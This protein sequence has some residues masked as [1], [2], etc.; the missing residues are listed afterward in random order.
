[1]QTFQRIAK[2]FLILFLALTLSIWL[3]SSPIIK[4]FLKAPLA[5]QGLSLSGQS[6]IRFNPFLTRV[7]IN[8]LVLTK[9]QTQT[10]VLEIGELTLQLALHQLLFDNIKVQT[11]KIDNLYLQVKQLPEKLE[12]AGFV[13][14]EQGAPAT[15]PSTKKV[16]EQTPTEFAYTVIMPALELSK[17][18]I[19][20]FAD[21]QAHNIH[22]DKF[23]VTDVTASITK[24][25]SQLSLTA[26]V[27]NAKT[28]FDA[29]VLYQNDATKI[30]S[31]FSLAQYPLAKLQGHLAGRVAQ[32]SQLEGKLS[33]ITEQKITLTGK[34]LEVLLPNVEVAPQDVI[35]KLNS[36]EK[37]YTLQVADML[38]QLKNIHLSLNLDK[39][40]EKKPQFSLDSFL[41]KTPKTITFIDHNLNPELQRTFLIDELSLGALSSIKTEEATPYQLIARSNEYEKFTFAGDIKPFAKIAEYHVKGDI[42]E[43]SL[44]SISSY[45][46]Q[47]MQL[48]FKSGQFN[49][50]IKGALI[51][52]KISGDINI[53]IKGLETSAA[54]NAEIDALKD[55]AT[56][57]LN[58]ALGMLKDGDGNVELKVPLSGSTKDPKFGVSSF[59][60][61]ITK[62]AVM[63]ATKS[64]LIKTFVPYA[65]VVSVAMTAGDFLLKVRFENLIYQTKQIQPQVEQEKYIQQFIALMNDKPKVNVK[66]C[67]ISVPADI[68]LMNGESITKKSAVSKLNSLAEKREHAFKDYIIKHSKIDSARLLLCAPK[69][70]SDK[71][72]QP[73]IELS[74]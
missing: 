41:L 37:S 22:I 19:D 42:S 65:N 2:W 62:K 66:I 1:M 45:V 27:D 25:V 17:G 52:D 61:L 28:L 36:E 38:A 29:D 8:N 67:A 21:N 14:S 68:G 70:D 39:Q 32:L 23:S 40:V 30:N 20:L 3:L 9:G 7:S 33:L 46:K 64:Y 18:D 26:L 57:P 59:I 55:N 69:I 51:A 47:A 73:R 31:N 53:V 60:T 71:K 15:K 49:T 63:S 12:I 24:V 74:V 58:A 72:A 50:K 44:P 35:S 48:E 6:T 56:M 54:D 16:V 4:Y 13:I 43:V 11:F 10:K 5:E 34:Q